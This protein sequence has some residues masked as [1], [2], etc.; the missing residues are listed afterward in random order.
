MGRVPG[1]EA[2]G[3]AKESNLSFGFTYL[4]FAIVRFDAHSSSK[5]DG[6]TTRNEE[7]KEKTTS[8]GICRRSCTSVVVVGQAMG[9][10]VRS[11]VSLLSSSTPNIAV[12]S[13]ARHTAAKSQAEA[14]H[15]GRHPEK[16]RYNG[17]R[18]SS[19]LFSF[20]IVMFLLPPLGQMINVDANDTSQ[21]SYRSRLLSILPAWD[22]CESPTVPLGGK[23]DDQKAN[24]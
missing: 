19:F 7:R 6:Q 24:T 20:L 23:K 22:V 15:V 1:P 17:S 12:V 5:R 16:S 10:Q 11:V 4:H 14:L 3:N 13:A 18:T 8:R 9:R 2:D 21:K